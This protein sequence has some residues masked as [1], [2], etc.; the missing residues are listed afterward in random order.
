M[1]LKDYLRDEIVEEANLGYISTSE[2]DRRLA[3]FDLARASRKDFSQLSCVRTVKDQLGNEVPEFSDET[4][5]T[6]RQIIPSEESEVLGYLAKPNNAS[7]SI[8]VIVIH[9]NKGLV[10]YVEDVARRLA[11]VGFVALAPDL[12]SR[13]GGTAA[14]QTSDEVTAALGSIDRIE[15]VEDLMASVSFL[16][17]AD[18]VDSNRIGV[19]GFCFG[20]GMA[21][22]LITKD[23]RVS[24]AVP[25]YGPNPPLED[26]PNIEAD[27]LAI[28][29]GLDQ[30]INAGIDE[31]E[32]AMIEAGKT[33]RKEIFD[34]AQHA[35]HND[36]NPDRYHP[37]AAT[38][39][40]AHA[41]DWLRG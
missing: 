35:F 22:R 26:V 32:L 13:R 10:P 2:R 34:G 31:I 23:S 30:R 12:L 11:R 41:L 18:F 20:G 5:S 6:F 4:I 19:V 38:Q 15:L 17:E 16:S 27:V 3:A 14:F 25:F 1:E 21:W 36:T 7:S 37:E 28:Y 8:G 9:E 33:F 29:G 40:W 39:A 24:R